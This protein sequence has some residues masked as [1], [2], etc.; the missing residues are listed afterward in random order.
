MDTC[1]YCI[2][3]G[4]EGKEADGLQPAACMLHRATYGER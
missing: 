2:H 3:T 1:N 4:M